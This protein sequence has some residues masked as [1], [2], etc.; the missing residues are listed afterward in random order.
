M[1]SDCTLGSRKGDRN[2][3]KVK[4]GYTWLEVQDR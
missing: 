3:L 4:W 1:L 2:I